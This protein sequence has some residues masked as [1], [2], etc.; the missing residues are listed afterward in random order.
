M[1]FDA[2]I[3]GNISQKFIKEKKSTNAINQMI[4]IKN[5]VPTSQGIICSPLLHE[6]K[7]LHYFKLTSFQYYG[8]QLQV[9]SIRVQENVAQ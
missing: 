5:K 1:S 8:T 6:G 9:P 2:N 4:N 3:H 7:P